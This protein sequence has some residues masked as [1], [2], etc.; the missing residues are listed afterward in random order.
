MLQA[1]LHRFINKPGSYVYRLS[2]TRLGQW[3]IGFVTRSR[4]IVQTIPQNKSLYQA[5]LDGTEEGLY[6]YPAGQDV[7]L[8]LRRM[9]NDAPQERVQVCEYECVCVCVCVSVCM[10]VC[11]C[12]HVCMLFFFLLALAVLGSSR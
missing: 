4:R 11:V 3:A 8:D 7:A 5:L 2:C 1:I 12:L 9:I 6:V 10:C